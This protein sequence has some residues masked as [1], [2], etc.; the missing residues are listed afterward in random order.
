LTENYRLPENAEA[1]IVGCVLLCPDTKPA[2]GKLVSEGDFSS[3]AY[4]AMFSAA[5]ELDELDSTA[6]H[7]AVK[8]RGY[9]LPDGFFAGL[10]DVAVSRHNVELYA[11]LLREDSQ[12]RQLKVRPAAAGRFPEAAAEGAV[13]ADTG[14]DGRGDGSR[15]DHHNRR[16][17]PPEN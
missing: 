13:P 12:R 10:G 17:L 3:P 5:M 9:S 8:R 6:F 4:G 7:D 2:V 15:R 1:S 16:F 11:R 14:A